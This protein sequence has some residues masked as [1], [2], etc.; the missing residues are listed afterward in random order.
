MKCILGSDHSEAFAFFAADVFAVEP[1][2]FDQSVVGF[3]AAV[4]KEQTTCA[5]SSDEPIGKFLLLRNA[6]EV[7]AMSERRGL[8]L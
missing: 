3:C 6:V 7:T 2:E 4:A 1:C 5:R 8:C